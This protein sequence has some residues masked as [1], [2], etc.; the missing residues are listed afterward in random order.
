MCRNI[1]FKIIKKVSSA[2]LI[3]NKKLKK[4][5][6]HSYTVQ[7]MFKKREN[8]KKV[9][10]QGFQEKIATYTFLIYVAVAVQVCA[11]HHP[12]LQLFFLVVLVIQTYIVNKSS[13]DTTK[14]LMHDPHDSLE[15][16]SLS[17]KIV[18]ESLI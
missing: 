5:I 1:V 3:L 18:M 12:W 2:T 15:N 9:T 10:C 7:R 13:I 17:K 4:L 8:K 14:L 11:T 16:R 6:C